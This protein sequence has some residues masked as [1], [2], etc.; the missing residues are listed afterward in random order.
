MESTPRITDRVYG[1]DSI[2]FVCALWVFFGHGAAPALPNP[3][4]AGSLAN[5]AFR[6]FFGNIWCGPAAVIVFFVISGFCIH[7][8]FAASDARPRLKEFYTR[9]LLRLLVPVAVAIPLSGLVGVRLALFEDSIL[10]SLF[11][12]LIYYICYPLLRAVRLRAGSWRGIVIVAFVIAYAVVATNPS[13]KNYPSYGPAFNWLL[14]LPCWLLGCMLAESTRLETCHV[15]SAGIWAWRVTIFLAACTC[16]VLRFH[17]P[18][19]YP[20]S[21]NLFAVVIALWLRREIDFRQRITPPAILEWAG[22]WSY[23]LYLIHVPAG[24][25][26]SK[27]LPSI[28]TG[29][30][31]WVIMVTFVFLACYIFYLLVE[32]PSHTV[33]RRA[34]QK[35]RPQ[36]RA[37]LAINAD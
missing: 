4:T 6:G 23:S 20:W 8:P 13:A 33:A 29:S 16:S 24:T 19:G 17:T 28:Q 37:P 22:L 26:F 1:L 36:A 12:E 15:S 5:L 11:A 2:R 34:A 21:L 35:F 9:R 25:L 32:Y 14:G 3:F 30:A 31:G 27:V 10:W 18:I 7:Y